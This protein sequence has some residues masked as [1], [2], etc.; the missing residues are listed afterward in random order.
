MIDVFPFAG[1]PVAVFGLGRSGM[2]AAEALQAGGASVTAWDDGIAGRAAAGRAGLA[3]RDFAADGYGDCEAVVLSPGIPRSHPAPHPA[4]AEA[5]ASGLA[6]INDIDLLARAQPEARFLGVTGTNGKSTTTALIG[7]ILEQTR[8]PVQAGGNLGPP[9]LSLAPLG[10]GCW[11]ALELSSYQLETAT[12]PRWDIAVYLNVTPDH[13]DR[14]GSV[15]GGR[16]AGPAPT[17]RF[18][19]RSLR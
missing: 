2:A 14:H 17:P 19:W 1:Y 6:V 7:H 5:L 13:L 16:I 9:A 15:A 18:R 3:L 11:Y 12:V 10:A 4:V 8:V